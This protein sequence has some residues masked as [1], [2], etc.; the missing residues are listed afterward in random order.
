[1]HCIHSLPISENKMEKEINIIKQIA[2]D[3]YKK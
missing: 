3:T 2:M 1:M